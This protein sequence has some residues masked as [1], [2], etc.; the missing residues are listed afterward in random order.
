MHCCI[1]LRYLTLQ[2]VELFTFNPHIEFNVSKSREK[3]YGPTV[4]ESTQ[5]PLQTYIFI[6]SSKLPSYL[7]SYREHQPGLEMKGTK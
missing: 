7:K 2:A 5:H 1:V 3:S 4:A 6:L